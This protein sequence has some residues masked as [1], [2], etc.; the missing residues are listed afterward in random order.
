M[1][2]ER[3]YGSKSST[4]NDDGKRDRK[5]ERRRGVGDEEGYSHSILVKRLEAA[6]CYYQ[7]LDQLKKTRLDVAPPILF[8]EHRTSP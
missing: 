8:C 7:I 1:D 3:L 6:H 4:T 5:G 2:H